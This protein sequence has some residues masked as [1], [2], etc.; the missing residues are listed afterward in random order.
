MIQMVTDQ[1]DYDAADDMWSLESGVRTESGSKIERRLNGH[2]VCRA[3]L[4]QAQS[5]DS[6]YCFI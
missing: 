5:A 2:N 3:W 1:T 4:E 6:N